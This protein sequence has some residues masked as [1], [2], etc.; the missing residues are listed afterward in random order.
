MQTSRD[1]VTRLA[2]LA[3]L[4]LTPEE[5]ET[6]AKD[7]ASI[8]AFFDQLSSIDTDHIGL[9]TN[10]HPCMENLRADAAAQSLPAGA[11]ISNAPHSRAGQFVVPRVI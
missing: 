5:I 11:V 7:F 8:I 1:Q 6:F 10:G 3:R 4:K 2:R 9:D